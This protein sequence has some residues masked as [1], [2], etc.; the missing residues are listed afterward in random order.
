MKNPTITITG[1]DRHWFNFAIKIPRENGE[2]ELKGAARNGEPI[3][4]PVNEKEH[5]TNDTK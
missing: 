1:I 5:E 3:E 4:I 2:T